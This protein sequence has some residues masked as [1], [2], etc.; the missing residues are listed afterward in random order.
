MDGGIDGFYTFLDGVLLDEDSEVFAQDFRA[1]EVR[2]H[3]EVDVWILQA[4]RETSFTETTFDK[5]ESSLT[6]SIE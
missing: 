2:R 5:W 4:K 3:V 6:S 1:A